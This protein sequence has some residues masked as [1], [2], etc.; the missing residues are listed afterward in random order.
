[1]RRLLLLF[2]IF[3]IVGCGSSTPSIPRPS[4]SA[5]Y[6][7]IDSRELV[8]YADN[9]IGET[10]QVSGKVFNII[11]SENFQMWIGKKNDAVYVQLDSP[12]S[13]VYEDDTV[14]VMATIGGF[15]T[16]TNSFGGEVKQP[17]L[18]YAYLKKY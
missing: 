18:I 6:K 15:A 12:M 11:D 8:S 10:V 17:M 3:A 16:G 4:G 14:T 13:G 7:S 5:S 2:A 1:M 9:H